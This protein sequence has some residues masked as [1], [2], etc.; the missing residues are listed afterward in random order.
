MKSRK[1]FYATIVLF[2][3]HMVLAIPHLHHMAITRLEL[4]NGGHGYGDLAGSLLAIDNYQRNRMHLFYPD[5][6][7]NL[8]KHPPKAEP[9]FGWKPWL[10]SK[11]LGSISF[12]NSMTFIDRYNL[13]MRSMYE[14][15]ED[16]PEENQAR[17]AFIASQSNQ[18]Q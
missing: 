5:D 3:L 18:S 9:P 12:R 8:N 7:E 15:P 13:R 2:L 16:F 10:C 1:W 11:K 17:D 6:S 14:H 4:A